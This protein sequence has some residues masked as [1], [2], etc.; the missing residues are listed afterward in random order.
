VPHVCLAGFLITNDHAL[1]EALRVDHEVTL[2]ADNI[3]LR[4]SQ[5]L[6]HSDVLV[7]DASG[8]RAALQ[9]LLRSLRRSWPELAIVLVDG[10]LTEDDKAD[11]FS[12]G[13]LDYFPA[14]CHVRLLVERL[15]VLARGRAVRR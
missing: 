4:D 8:I 13:V 9:P 11:A 12:L 3:G 10:N 5:A 15:E 7:L 2:V 14:P 1:V 6:A